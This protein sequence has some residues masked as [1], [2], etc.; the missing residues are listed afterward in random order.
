MVRHRRNISKEDVSLL[1]RS[2]QAKKERQILQHN[3]TGVRL[4]PDH[5]VRVVVKHLDPLII[6]KQVIDFNKVAPKDILFK[7]KEAL[8]TL[9]RY[10]LY[11]RN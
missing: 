2:H 1:V 3:L 10:S 6:S 4:K 11:L 9:F 7:E 5:A 8:Q